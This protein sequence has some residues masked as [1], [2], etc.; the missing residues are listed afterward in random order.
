MQNNEFLE[1]YDKSIKALECL[2]K[3]TKNRPSEKAWNKYAFE[4]GYLLSDTI[5]YVS[6]K[7]FNT[8]CREII[9]R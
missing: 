2:I 4:H 8:I 1:L 6:G 5:G 9:K 7:G 3:E